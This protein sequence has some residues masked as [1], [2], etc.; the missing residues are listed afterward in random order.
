MTLVLDQ[1]RSNPKVKIS[2]VRFRSILVIGLYQPIEFL[3]F[4]FK[5]RVFA[6]S[7][8]DVLKIKQPLGFEDAIA[9][10]YLEFLVCYGL[11]VK[12]LFQLWTLK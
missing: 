5:E 11:N 2:D 9:F 4:G 6:E 1:M 8:V 12:E 7:K 3:E 10:L